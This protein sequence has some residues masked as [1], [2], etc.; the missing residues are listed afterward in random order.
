MK[1]FIFLLLIGCFTLNGQTTERA[2]IKQLNANE[3]QE[4]FDILFAT[5][6]NNHPG[7]YDYQSEEEVA[8]TKELLQAQIKEA[9]NGLA[10]YK[11]VSKLIAAVGDAH[12]YVINPYYQNILRE[13]R[14]FPIR[15]KIDNNQITINGERIKSINGHSEAEILEVLQTFANS[16]GNTIPYKNAFIELEFPIKYFTFL[17]DASTFEVLLENGKSMTLEGKSYFESGLRP[18]LPSPTF[19]MEGKQATIKIPSWE[20]ET[21]SSFNRDLAEMAQRSTLGKFIK[22]SMEQAI[23]AQADHLLIDLR[24]NTGGKSGPAAILLS[25]LIDQPFSYYREIRV[26]SDR[27]PTKAYI[28]NGDLVALYESDAAKEMIE[29]V[30]GAFVFKEVFLSKISPQAQQFPGTVELLV[31]KYSL[32]VSTDVVAI[33]KQ[34]REVAITGREIGGSL[35]HY[36]AGSYLQLVLPNTGMEV[37]IPVQR[38]AY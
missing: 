35:V 8:Q 10:A 29:A 5:L 33:L 23:T 36:C 25:Y 31:D 20:D 16:D 27:F 14:L 2:Y 11:I 32:S 7:F 17:D 38:L 4:D 1:Y 18:A 15:P 13:E 22:S 6:T 37:T 3:L 19:T 9:K 30:D 34:N 21:A 24:G 28:A 26:A 12:T